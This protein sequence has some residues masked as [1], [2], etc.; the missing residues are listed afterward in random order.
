MIEQLTLTNFRNHK[1]LRINT[2]C[3]NVALLGENG[4][5]KTNVLEALSLLNG[6]TGFRRSE[7]AEISGFGLAEYA[8]AAVLRDGTEIS[9]FWKDSGSRSCRIN[10]ERA[11][12]FELAKIIG[13][14]WL[15]PSQDMLFT[16]A[17]SDRRVFFDNLIS[18]FDPLHMGRVARLGKLLSERGFALKNDRDETWL[19]L[20]EKNIAETASSIA[21]ARVNFI[22]ELNHVFEFGEIGVKGILE[23]RV[24]NGEKASDFE[25]FYMNYLASNRVLVDGKMIIDGAHKTD[26]FVKNKVLGLPANLTSSGQQ[27]L[28]LNRLIIA[29]AKLVSAKNPKLPLLILLD[30]VDSH[31]DK[32]ARLELFSELSKT[33]AQIWTTGTDDMAVPSDFCKVTL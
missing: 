6:G 2:E 9:V 15:T 23:Q 25:D 28:L 17:P 26:F 20:I 5:G 22:A 12:L 21:A 19:D 16:S 13:I 4:A 1:T 7:S 8:S 18:G 29:N 30:E 11:R 32:N 10:G 31:L 3:K 27:K 24:I 33:T 14:I